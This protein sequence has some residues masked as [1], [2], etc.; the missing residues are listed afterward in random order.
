MSPVEKLNKII[1]LLPMEVIVDID[2][3]ITDW[4][5]GG[6][7]ENDP[8]IEQQVRYAERVANGVKEKW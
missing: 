2:K 4:L 8:Y 3:R 5:A 6:G 7:N 1:H